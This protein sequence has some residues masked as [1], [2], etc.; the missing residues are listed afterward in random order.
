MVA[1]HYSVGVPSKGA[2]DILEALN[3]SPDCRKLISGAFV[4]FS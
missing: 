2:Y 3:E 4:C 1:E